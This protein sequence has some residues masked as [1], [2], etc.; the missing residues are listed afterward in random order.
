MQER[1]N[2][3]LVFRI[4]TVIE[5]YLKIRYVFVLVNICFD[6]YFIVSPDFGRFSQYL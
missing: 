6:I 2:I 1:K 4:L 5:I 3:D